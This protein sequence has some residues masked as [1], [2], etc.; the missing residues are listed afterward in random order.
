VAYPRWRRRLR[1]LGFDM[2]SEEGICWA[3]FHRLS[4]SR[5]VPFLT[6]LEQRLGLRRLPSVSPWIVFVA[7]RQSGGVR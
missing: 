1:A 7:Q 2:V 3:P 6:R 4:D 5:F